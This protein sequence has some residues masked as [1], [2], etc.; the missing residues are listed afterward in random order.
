MQFFMFHEWIRL[1]IHPL[2]IP[3]AFE[4][5]PAPDISRLTYVVISTVFLIFNLL[6]CRIETRDNEMSHSII[7]LDRKPM[8][9]EV[10]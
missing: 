8:N 7:L 2:R 10:L 4:V 5:L 3:E 1:G 6:D 9:S